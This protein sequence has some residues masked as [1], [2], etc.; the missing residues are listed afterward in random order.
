MLVKRYCLYKLQLLYIHICNYKQETNTKFT[1]PLSM[2]HI[3]IIPSDLM[4]SKKKE[5]LITR[6]KNKNCNCSINNSEI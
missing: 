5:E 2:I 4:N 6:K 1:E 3:T